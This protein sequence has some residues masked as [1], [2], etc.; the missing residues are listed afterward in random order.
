M[1][2]ADVFENFRNVCLENYKL[3]PAHYLTVPS[4]IFDAMLK[5]TKVELELLND[6]NK[7]LIVEP[8]IRGGIVTCVE[9]NVIANNPEAL[10]EDYDCT[11]ERSYL[12]FL[13]VN[14]LYG[15]TMCR[16]MP[17]SDLNG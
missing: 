6:Y 13:D 2:L 16:P 1:I 5:Y 11:K 17:K 4:L 14:G 3:D 7:Y 12:A 10:D 9:R 8:G 15:F